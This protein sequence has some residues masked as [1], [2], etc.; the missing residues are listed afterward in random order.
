VALRVVTDAAT[1]P[2]LVALTGDGF[3]RAPASGF[4]EP[5][6]VRLSAAR[7]HGWVGNGHQARVVRQIIQSG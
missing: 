2:D 4:N 1:G 7:V 6:R 5:H 3:A